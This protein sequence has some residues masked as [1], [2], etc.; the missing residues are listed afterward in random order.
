VVGARSGG[1][2]PA[3]AAEE[4]DD[5]GSDD[6]AMF[7]QLNIQQTA[8]LRSVQK[9]GSVLITGPLSRASCFL[10]ESLHAMRAHRLSIPGRLVSVRSHKI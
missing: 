6:D 10:L 4:E 2:G 1:G 5:A 9:G 3:E 8:V 7:F